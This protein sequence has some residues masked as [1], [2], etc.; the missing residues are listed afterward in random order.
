MDHMSRRS[1][2]S[3]A[4]AAT[5]VAAGTAPVLAQGSALTPGQGDKL[6]PGVSRK[7]WGTRNSMIPAY[8]SVAMVDII[9]RP[10]AKS[11]NPSMPNDM[12]CHVP[13]GELRVT[14]KDGTNFTAK[15]GDVWTC[16]KGE[17][18]AL[19]NTGKTVAIMRVINL[20]PA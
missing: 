9:Y 6:P 16:V 3:L 4:M 11:A 8:K 14:R 5:A 17:D 12:V 19:E 2:L 1:A 18:E 10:G 7:N 13:E 15:K 20:I